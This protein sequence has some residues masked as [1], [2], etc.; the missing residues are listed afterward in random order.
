M[1]RKSDDKISSYTMMIMSHTSWQKH[2]VVIVILFLFN[3]HTVPKRYNIAGD[4]DRGEGRG[5]RERGCRK[6]SS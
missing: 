5:V 4:E 2:F 6:E 3:P 1:S